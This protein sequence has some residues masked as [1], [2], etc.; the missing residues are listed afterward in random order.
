MAVFG[1]A[2]HVPVGALALSV[3]QR[4]ILRMGLT[5]S[6]YW[7]YTGERL[8]LAVR[9]D[10]GRFGGEVEQAMSC[11]RHGASLKELWLAVELFK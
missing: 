9:A 3:L 6:G 5:A 11:L 4:S 8:G 7:L 2:G 10:V 1:P